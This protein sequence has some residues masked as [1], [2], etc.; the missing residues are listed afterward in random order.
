MLLR[1]CPQRPVTT[2]NLTDAFNHIEHQ[3]AT[4]SDYA[5]AFRQF[6]K[7]HPELK[8]NSN[9][10]IL[11]DSY[12]GHFE[13]ITATTLEEL[14]QSPDIQAQLTFNAEYVADQARQLERT[15]L[16]KELNRPD[17]AGAPLDELRQFAAAK[18]EEARLKGMSPTALRQELHASEQARLKALNEKPPVPSTWE[19]RVANDYF[20]RGETIQLSPRT[21]MKLEKEDMR[22]ILN[23]CGNNNVDEFLNI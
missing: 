17:L 12:H 10:K 13:D 23:L 21:F 5:T 22:R 7:Q 20:R 11:A 8:L 6:F 19:V 9:E 1:A 16:V 18:R 3:L 14:L 4:N 15:A 2:A